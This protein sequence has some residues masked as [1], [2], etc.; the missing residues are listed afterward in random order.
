MFDSMLTVINTIIDLTDAIVSI[1]RLINQTIKSSTIPFF[2]DSF[3]KQCLLDYGM[4][5]ILSHP[6]NFKALLGAKG[7]LKVKSNHRS[8]CFPVS[9]LGNNHDDVGRL[10]RH[11]PNH[12]VWQADR[13][14]M[15]MIRR[16]VLILVMM[17][18]VVWIETILSV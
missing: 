17:M 13:R 3:S 1:H 6:M 4:I 2:A 7:P 11:L 5:I 10:W 8:C 14:G 15:G 9:L 16:I 12:L 18:T